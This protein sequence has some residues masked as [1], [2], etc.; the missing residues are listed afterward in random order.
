MKR[1]VPNANDQANAEP[2]TTGIP[3]EAKALAT[4]G[5][6]RAH[7]DGCQRRGRPRPPNEPLTTLRRVDD[8]FWL[9]S[10]RHAGR[11]AAGRAGHRGHR[12]RFEPATRGSFDLRCVLTE[13]KT[14][15]WVFARESSAPILA[16]ADPRQVDRRIGNVCVADP[17]HVPR[18]RVSPGPTSATHEGT[19]PK[20]E[21]SKGEPPKSPSESNPRKPALPAL[22]ATTPTPGAAPPSTPNP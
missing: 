22:S 11:R 2:E 19:P 16:P 9:P 4:R 18:P 1:S 3:S 8:W 12:W 7:C 17:H 6:V 13:T 20:S 21:L 10:V 5:T 14:C 15:R